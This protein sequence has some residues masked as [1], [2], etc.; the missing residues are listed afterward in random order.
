[1]WVEGEAEVV[2]EEARG[3]GPG[4]GL[5]AIAKTLY[6]NVYN[7]NSWIASR[8]SCDV[9]R[10]WSLNPRIQPILEAEEPEVRT[11]NLD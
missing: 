4:A 6:Y 8:G 11:V 2:D 3:V 9:E 1:M 5:I 7:G 10:A